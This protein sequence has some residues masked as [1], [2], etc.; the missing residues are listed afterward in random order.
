MMAREITGN[1]LGTAS[2]LKWQKVSRMENMGVINGHDLKKIIS[3]LGDIMTERL[4]RVNFSLANFVSK[5]LHVRKKHN[6]NLC[7]ILRFKPSEVF[8][9]DS[10]F[11]IHQSNYLKQLDV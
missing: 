11:P 10:S 8:H 6:H 4:L 1:K 3:T 9:M 5:I 7:I 2:G